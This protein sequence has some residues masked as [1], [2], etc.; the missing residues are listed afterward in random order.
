MIKKT[1]FRPA[2]IMMLVCLITAAFFLVGS[3]GFAFAPRQQAEA[4]Y[5]RGVKLAGERQFQ[6]AI[7]AYTR[8]IQL[9]GSV[10][11]YY[12]ARANSKR[13][14][15]FYKDAIQDYDRA[16]EI[17]PRYVSAFVN[18]G[19]AKY[20]SNDHNGSIS[21][22]TRA[23]S[24]DP[25]SV[26]C[27]KNRALSR[28]AL[29]DLAGAAADMETYLKS[30]PDDAEVRNAL[31]LLKKKLPAAPPP[32]VSATEA[33]KELW[34][35]ALALTKAKDFAGAVEA[36][37]KAIGFTPNNATLYYNRG[38]NKRELKDYPG[39]LSDYDKAVSLDPANPSIYL[40]RGYVKELMGD[41]EGAEADYLTCL[42]RNPD[43][44]G[45]KQGLARVAQAKSFEQKIKDAE[46]ALET[47][48]T[49]ENQVPPAD[50]KDFVFPKK[51]TLAANPMNSGSWTLADSLWKKTKSGTGD[52]RLDLPPAD[53]PPPLNLLT[54]TQAQYTGAVSM[55]ME[56]MR[57]VFG[58]MSEA[59][60]KNF[61]A[62]WAPMFDFPFQAAIHYLNELN[63]LLAKFLAVRA[64]LAQATADFDALMGESTIAA[65]LEDGDSVAEAMAAA[66]LLKT[67]ILM[68][69]ARLAKTAEEIRLLGDPPNPVEEK[70][71]RRKAHKDAVEE[72]EKIAKKT[73]VPA[74]KPA[75]GA[76][77]PRPGDKLVRWELADT[78]V[79]SRDGGT[80]V[81]AGGMFIATFPEGTGQARKIVTLQWPAPPPTLVPGEK[82]PCPATFLN[83]LN[84]RKN[85]VLHTGFAFKKGFAADYQPDV[86]PYSLDEEETQNYYEAPTDGEYDSDYRGRIC[87]FTVSNEYFHVSCIYR[88]VFAGGQAEAPAGARSTGDEKADKLAFYRANIAYFQDR[89]V[90]LNQQRS[91]ALPQNRDAI[92]W[93]I[94]CVQAD[95]Q[96]EQDKIEMLE[97]GEWVRTRTAFDDFCL[98]RMIQIGQEEARESAGRTRLIL[99][100]P[101]LVALLPETERHT[102]QA[103][104]SAL[105]TKALG[106]GDFS[107]VRQQTDAIAARVQ[108]YWGREAKKSLNDAWWADLKLGIARGLK[109]GADVSLML[110]SFGAASPSPFVSAGNL[111][112]SAYLGSTGYV[113]GGPA[114]GVREALAALHPV[115]M[116][117][118]KAYDGYNQTVLDHST[119]K[120]LIDP[121][122]GQPVKAGIAGALWEGGKVALAA[123]SIQKIVPWIA[124][125][126][127]IGGAVPSGEKW[128]TVEAQIREAQFQSALAQGRMNVRLFAQRQARLNQARASKA[129]AEEIAALNRQAEEAAML[130]KLSYASKAHLNQL[131]AGGERELLRGYLQHEQNFMGRVFTS[132]RN[133]MRNDGWS[134]QTYQSYS[135]SASRGRAGM[136]VDYGVGNPERYL[137][138]ENGRIQPNPEY[139]NWLRGIT[140][141]GVRR[142]TYDFERAGQRHLDDAFAEVVGQGRSTRESFV[143]FTTPGHSEAYADRAWI[144]AGSRPTA[145]FES[146]DPR[147]VQQAA[148]VTMFKVNGLPGGHP[149]LPHYIDL[150]E[151]CRTL[152]KDINTKLAGIN[153]ANPHVV[154]ADSPLGAA[155]RAVQDHILRVRDIMNDF[156][157][158]RIGPIEAERALADVTGGEGL[159][160]VVREFG[161]IMVGL[162]RR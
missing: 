161:D 75:G 124:K 37:T 79:M 44:D 18:R 85:I 56:G 107:R 64:A 126:M 24:L 153:P 157:N 144:G 66:G 122:T 138:D 156:A 86:E 162:T 92:D 77:E 95:L 117:G 119:G 57:V 33:A 60:T 94:M 139:Y 91:Q 135:N 84:P 93:Q 111:I 81:R 113:D 106:S 100:G 120:P 28:Q 13:S 104:L 30:V 102:A 39:A 146:V 50:F 6:T 73:G 38:N 53:C 141:K 133:R 68:L 70:G 154:G 128:P 96:A 132:F 72:A 20:E 158:N 90:S 34:V 147:W 35:K 1:E 29:G 109:T 67:K 110:A 136:D 80:A 40:N 134:D 65:G 108:G 7:S 101:R 17:D 97:T 10:A 19:I 42:D 61:E 11:K 36:Y 23:L 103:E 15:G 143:N 46:K 12:Y 51:T 115:L 129:S 123:F 149:S 99:N 21:D 83:S 78:Q 62:K 112:Y 32:P 55:A 151:K 98:N 114:Q 137:R 89:L 48:R 2:A 5:Q 145:C 82:I 52:V 87:A 43:S 76:S 47:A 155:N 131:A 16:I 41:L 127:G 71:R 150:Q 27:Y 26:K 3:G 130:I 54:V 121:K 9:D 118:I 8:A 4:E 142:S 116:T 25:S 22:Y 49:Q 69:E 14:L 152:V 160:G 58:P 148:D 105:M 63:P 125:K 74:S 159:P 140:Q 45:P 88:G 59:E 31:A